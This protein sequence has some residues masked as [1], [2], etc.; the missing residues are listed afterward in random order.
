MRKV[1]G[2]TLAP[3]YSWFMGLSDAC[4]MSYK[5]CLRA[6]PFDHAQLPSRTGRAGSLPPVPA[7]VVTSSSPPTTCLKLPASSPRSSAMAGSS[8]MP[9]S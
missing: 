7:G 9:L 6:V 8:P 1:G 4:A 3:G 2:L 5:L